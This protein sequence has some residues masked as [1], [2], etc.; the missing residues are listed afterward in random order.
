ML[1]NLNY[2]HLLNKCYS[3]LCR[4]MYFLAHNQSFYLIIRGLLFPLDPLHTHLPLSAY[5]NQRNVYRI[6]FSSSSRSSP[7]V[8]VMSS[9]R[10][11]LLLADLLYVICPKVSQVTI[12]K[13]SS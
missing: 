3:S 6:F 5:K 9:W 4:F 12:S 11:T 10:R 8:D 2:V 13:L 1:I 7:V